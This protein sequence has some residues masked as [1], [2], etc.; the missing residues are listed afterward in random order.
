MENARPANAAPKSPIKAGK[1]SMDKSGFITNNAPAKVIKRN[2][3]CLFSIL[4]FRIMNPNT[5]AKKGPSL[6]KR[7]E[8]DKIK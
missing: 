3:I 1:K 6:D 4:S 8:S 2:I 7:V 5:V